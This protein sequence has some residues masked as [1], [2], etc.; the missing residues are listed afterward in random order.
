MERLTKKSIFGYGYGDG[1]ESRKYNR[2]NSCDTSNIPEII[3]KLGQ[4]ED[5]FDF[6]DIKSL[7]ELEYCL[8]K[9]KN[10]KLYS[11]NDDLCENYLIDRQG[12]IFSK[13]T[14]M[15]L[16]QYHNNQG[17][18]YVMIKGKQKLIHRLVAK[19]FIDN[20]NNLFEVNHINEIKDDNRVENLEWCSRKCNTT[21]K[22]CH[23]RHNEWNK[24]PIDQY[25]LKGNFI[26][27]WSY[28]LEIEKAGVG[29]SSNIK[30]CCKNELSIHK[31]Y[32]WRWQ[33][34]SFESRRIKKDYDR[35]R[36]LKI[37]RNK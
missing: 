31:G 16:K 6:Y 23:L 2:N 32:V 24:K 3:N 13:E 35:A 17:Y 11:I 8:S 33:G 25:D 37:R 19:T 22:N 15:V 36:N 20:P 27:T 30:Q 12:N 5:L 18:A 21:Y 29:K 1:D 7:E 9:Y 4:L 34:E 14:K 26:K 28:A 10:N